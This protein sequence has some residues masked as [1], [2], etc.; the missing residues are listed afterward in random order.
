MPHNELG[1]K[2]DLKELEL[3]LG[4][5]IAGMMLAQAAFIIAFIQYLK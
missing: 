5:W 1:T 2:A 3:R 4:K